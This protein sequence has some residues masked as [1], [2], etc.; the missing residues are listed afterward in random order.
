MIETG[1][2]LREFQGIDMRVSPQRLRQLFSE[3][4]CASVV[5]VFE[6]KKWGG[7]LLR[8]SFKVLTSPL[9][10]EKV[11]EW[12]DDAP[13]ARMVSEMA[14]ELLANFKP[15]AYCVGTSAL[16]DTSCFS[17]VEWRSTMLKFARILQD[18]PLDQVCDA[19]NQNCK[20]HK[21]DS[22]CAFAIIIFVQISP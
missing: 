12:T 1:D 8:L 13:S 22:G 2:V 6:K 7:T 4:V 18:K 21:F 5:L 20:L 19:L 15:P 17:D 3:R 16:M 9:R 10:I 11:P 14:G